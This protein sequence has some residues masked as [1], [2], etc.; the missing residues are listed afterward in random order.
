MVSYSKIQPSLGTQIA[1]LGIKK[2]SKL[3]KTIVKYVATQTQQPKDL[4]ERSFDTYLDKYKDYIENGVDDK[5]IRKTFKEWSLI[6]TNIKFM[7][8][9]AKCVRD[10]IRS[11]VSEEHQTV[12]W[13]KSKGYGIHYS[14]PKEVKRRSSKRFNHMLNQIT[15]RVDVTKEKK[16]T[17]MCFSNLSLTLT[18]CNRVEYGEKAVNAIIKQFSSL[19]LLKAPYVVMTT[20]HYP[21]NVPIELSE[22][23]VYLQ[24]KLP[25]AQTFYSPDN[26]SYLTVIYNID[27]NRKCKFIVRESGKI[28]LS[29]SMS[30]TLLRPAYNSVI[31]S[32]I[33]FVNMQ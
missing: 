26:N 9:V 6:D 32:I 20:I 33:E 10:Y 28:M 31:G 22:L 5:I 24:D 4:V 15:M 14:P 16:V 18:G 12:V 19:E 17:V 7:E 23:A 21:M 3:Y 1:K 8:Y 25:T 2:N 30:P 13:S 11:K 27:E 29:G